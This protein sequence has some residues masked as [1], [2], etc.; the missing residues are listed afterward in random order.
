MLVRQ[1]KAAWRQGEDGVVVPDEVACTC[2]C[3]ETKGEDVLVGVDAER[4]CGH[5]IRELGERRKRIKV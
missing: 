2:L 4:V 5:E 1:Q 3:E